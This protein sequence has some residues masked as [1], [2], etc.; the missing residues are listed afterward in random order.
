[1]LAELDAI[2]D[3]EP[4]EESLA[5]AVDPDDPGRL[6][7]G[8]D[9]RMQRMMSHTV[10]D[11]SSRF[12]DLMAAQKL[13]YLR[14][15]LARIARDLGLSD[16]DE[17]ALM[18][19]AR[20]FTQRISRYLYEQRDPSGR[21]L[22]AGIR[23]CSRLNL[24]WECWAIWAERMR[25]VPGMPGPPETIHPD[26]PDLTEI[27]RLWSLTI[28]VLPGS[29]QFFRPW[30]LRCLPDGYACGFTLRP[31]LAS[32]HPMPL[33]LLKIDRGAQS[34]R[35]IQQEPALLYPQWPV[36]EVVRHQ[37]GAAQL[38]G[39]DAGG[40]HRDVRA[41]ERADA[42]LDHAANHDRQVRRLGSGA[43]SASL[44]K[45]IPS[46]SVRATGWLINSRS[47]RSSIRQTRKASFR[48]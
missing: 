7:I 39:E 37:E 41:H 5:G 25:H 23:Y 4:L 32:S 38:G 8:A 35:L 47:C 29:G 13:Q 36:E 31:A 9:W 14:R 17:A 48:P 40:R 20:E 46:Q 42:A 28:E 43:I 11:P 18:G 44:R 26:D 21:P 6:I 2:S 27:A 30:K 12:V 1:L 10:V 16:I 22:Y 45:A 19:P 33:Q 34:G 15:P 3:D 24:A